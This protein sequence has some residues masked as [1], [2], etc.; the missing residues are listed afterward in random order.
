MSWNPDADLDYAQKQ[1]VLRDY[2]DRY[3]PEYVIETGLY[4]LRGSC[5]QFVDEADVIA[6]DPDIENRRAAMD[7]GCIAVYP[8]AIDLKRVLQVAV[9]AP[10]M[11]W[12][13]AHA[14]VEKREDNYSTLREE[15]RGIVA[16]RHAPGSIVLIDDMR[17]MGLP[18]WPTL[19]EVRALTEG[20]WDRE[21]RDDVM[22]LT[23]KEV[24]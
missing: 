24:E 18:G 11:F 23:P 6:F 13:D 17:M 10:A 4:A 8:N 22:R 15:L 9:R 7:A 5:F 3:R 20:L 19:T 16:W 1:Q 21:E 2:F 14:V 12:L